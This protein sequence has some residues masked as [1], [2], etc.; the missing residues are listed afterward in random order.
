MAWRPPNGADQT[1]ATG[2]RMNLA[3]QVIGFG[4]S[5]HR[6]MGAVRLLRSIRPFRQFQLELWLETK[7]SRV[8]GALTPASPAGGR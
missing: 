4:G 1:E 6:R 5:D 3:F 8:C 2:F 7:K